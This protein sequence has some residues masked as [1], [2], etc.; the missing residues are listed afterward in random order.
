MGFL[1][2]TRLSLPLGSIVQTV[3]G[4]LAHADPKQA[5]HRPVGRKDSLELTP[6]L[7]S[8]P[9]SPR[10]QQPA[11]EAAQA[12][13]GWQKQLGKA[14]RLGAQHSTDPFPHCSSVCVSIGQENMKLNFL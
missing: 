13:R 5:M 12:R 8:T 14:E 7:N 1:H 3:T 6:G 4:C 11:L 2:S 10:A 9:T